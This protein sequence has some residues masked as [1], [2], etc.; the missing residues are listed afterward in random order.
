MRMGGGG[1]TRPE[2]TMHT[3]PIRN[4]GDADS[5]GISAEDTDTGER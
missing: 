4:V 2:S 5:S 1:M 3:I